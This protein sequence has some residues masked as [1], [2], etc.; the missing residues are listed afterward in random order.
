[1]NEIQQLREK[2][3]AYN[4]AYHT[5][6]SS[7][8]SDF[9]YDALM[10][11]LRELEAEHPEYA[12][13][14]S[15]TR[16]VGAPIP[17]G[18]ISVTHEVPLMSLQDIF[19]REELL[20]FNHNSGFAYVVEP[21]IDGLSVAAEY[22][23]GRLFRIATRGNGQVG[24]DVTHNA[25]TLVNLP[26]SIPY[27]RRVVVHGEA[28]MT[29]AAFE[30]ANETHEL[31]GLKPFANPRNAAVGVLRRLDSSM[32]AVDLNFLLF[33]VQ[34]AEGAEFETDSSALAQMEQWGFGVIPHEVFTDFGA[35]IAAI[36]AIGENRDG[37]P[38]PLDGAV[39]KLDS[40]EQRA[41]LGSTAR[42]PRWAVA[43]KFP[44]EEK[45]ATLLEIVI[46]VG[47]TGALT[48]RALLSPVRL[49]G[50]TVTAATLHNADFIAEK[51]IRVG[52]TVI[53]R[54]A[55]EIIPE[56]LGAD[57]SRRPEG[58]SP[59]AFPT[60]CP[61]C[62]AEAA[63]EDGEAVSRCTGADCPAQRARNLLHF[64]SRDAMDIEGLGAATVELL[65]CRHVTEIYGLTLEDILKLP[66]FKTKSAQNLLDGIEKSKSRGLSRVLFALGVRH[67][68]QKTAKII[69]ERFGSMDALL[70]ADAS[71]LTAIRD[72]GGVIAESVYAWLHS[73]AGA[74]VIEGLKSAGVSMEQER[75]ELGDK[76]AGQTFVLTGALSRYT[77]DAAARL[78]ERQGGK[79]SGSVSKKTTAVVAGENAGSKLD[80]AVSLGVKIL[81][82]TELESLLNTP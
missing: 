22:R 21:K 77:R 24:E 32:P 46:Q 54:K 62:G 58:A 30:K 57:L 42:A 72:V 36:D 43:Y 55:G 60:A 70:A 61:V 8:V 65:D 47:R 73:E 79:V 63:R 52:D 12:D 13:E 18:K 3:E 39:V 50:T 1:M 51:D 28:H 74:R 80:K 45:P 27:G 31:L 64:A 48:P 76:L 16:R 78:I 9:E 17:Q 71:E 5:I 35:V 38:Y 26:P 53:V 10:R 75:E 59:Y 81:S 29:F 23:G 15:I 67:L 56:V 19:S 14:N 11:R 4:H 44:P 66:G 40:L 25:R 82:E 6:G 37:Y 69:A 2:L 49:A 68:G 20:K 33:D 41:R 34:L 7:P